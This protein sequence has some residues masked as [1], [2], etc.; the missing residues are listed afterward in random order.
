MQILIPTY[1]D[2]NF[3]VPPNIACIRRYWPK[4]RWDILVVNGGKRQIPL[5]DDKVRVLYLN[6]DKNYGSNLLHAIDTAVDDEHLLL[7]LDDYMLFHLDHSVI[8][9]AV[10]LVKSPEI[11]SVRLSKMYTPE[12]EPYDADARFTYIDMKAQYSFSQQ[13]CFW[14]TSVF[15]D[16]LREG[17]DPWET[18]L[19]GSGRIEHS[20]DGTFRPFL[21]VL[22][23][24]L[25]YHNILNKGVFDAN[26]TKWLL[27]QSRW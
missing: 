1:D 24:A 14:E 10:S 18:E 26:A 4:C 23:P 19:N 27:N 22:V 6:E 17:E 11:P 9:A 3:L 8:N 15:R 20:P 5:N 21:G 2:Y 16:N 13:A 25:E 12:R 7:W